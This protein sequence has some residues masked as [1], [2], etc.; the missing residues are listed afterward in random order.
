MTR[1]HLQ[2]PWNRNERCPMEKHFSACSTSNIFPGIIRV[3]DNSN[4]N[5]RLRADPRTEAVVRGEGG[6]GWQLGLM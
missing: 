3:T 6:K 5:G 1:T 4:D 2:G